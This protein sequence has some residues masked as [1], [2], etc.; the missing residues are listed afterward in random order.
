M[1]FIQFWEEFNVVKIGYNKI[2]K[3][4]KGKNELKVYK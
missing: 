4:I 3:Y 1:D 2:F